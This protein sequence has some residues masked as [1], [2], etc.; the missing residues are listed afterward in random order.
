MISWVTP[1]ASTTHGPPEGSES[2]QSARCNTQGHGSDI[3]DGYG[4]TGTD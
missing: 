4:D 3:S 1:R 2:E